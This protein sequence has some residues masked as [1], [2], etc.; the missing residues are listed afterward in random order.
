MIIGS[1]ITEDIV[2]QDPRYVKK[3]KITL[4][5][6]STYTLEQQSVL[7]TEAIKK[8]NAIKEEYGSGIS[9]LIRIYNACGEAISLQT[10][11]DWHGHIWKYPFDA[12]IQNGQWSAIL[13]VHTSGGMAGAEGAVIY[14]ASQANQDIFLGWE[15]PYIGDNHVYVESREI[16]HWPGKVEWDYMQELI[17]KTGS[18]TFDKWQNLAVKGQIGQHSSPVVD[19]VITHP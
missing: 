3:E 11:K 12:V 7:D 8:V 1:A 19:F 10:T 5:D 4:S 6:I 13:Y 14:R 17:E 2:R 16:S 18:T 9:A 15:S